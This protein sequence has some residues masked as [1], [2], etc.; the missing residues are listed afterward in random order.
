MFTLGF[1]EIGPHKF[2]ITASMR[3]F[4]VSVEEMLLLTFC[5]LMV[6][7]PTLL[8]CLLIGAKGEDTPVLSPSLGWVLGTIPRSPSL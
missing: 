7:T 5:A 1:A 3:I 2:Y 4:Y 8:V 6:C